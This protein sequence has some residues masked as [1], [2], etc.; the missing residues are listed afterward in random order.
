MVRLMCSAAWARSARR[1]PLSMAACAVAR[2][3]A[4]LSHEAGS[5]D[6]T[7]LAVTV[8]P[9]TSVTVLHEGSLGVTGLASVAGLPGG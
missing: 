6:V 3:E 5:G 2:A 9:G 7:G 1:L 4:H 8:F